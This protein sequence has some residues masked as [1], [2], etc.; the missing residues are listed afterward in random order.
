MKTA[1]YRVVRM[2]VCYQDVE[3]EVMYGIEA[4]CPE[5]GKVLDRVCR[6]SENEAEVQKLSEMMNQ[7]ELSLRHFRCV[8]DDFSSLIMAD[9][10]FSLPLAFHGVI[11]RVRTGSSPSPVGGEQLR[12]QCCHCGRYSLYGFRGRCRRRPFLGLNHCWPLTDTAAFSAAY[13]YAAQANI[14]L[15]ALPLEAALS[16][17]PRE[18]RPCTLDNPSRLSRSRLSFA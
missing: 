15:P 8:V 2:S 13:Y 6:I 7:N 14:S 4:I 3:E 5:E 16:F 11:V 12:P 18:I 9:R 10:S 1:S 17:P